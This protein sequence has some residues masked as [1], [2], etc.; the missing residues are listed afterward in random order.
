MYSKYKDE[1]AKLYEVST[2]IKST[3]PGCN[4]EPPEMRQACSKCLLENTIK[5]EIYPPLDCSVQDLMNC[6]FETENPIIIEKE[7]DNYLISLMEGI[8]TLYLAEDN[9][10][11]DALIL[12]LCRISS[13]KKYHDK[14]KEKV[15]KLF[16]E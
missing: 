11:E 4:I 13:S 14:I 3:C 12:S 5:K 9:N 8:K 10:L 16:M 7:G 1:L 15:Q 6:F 2:R